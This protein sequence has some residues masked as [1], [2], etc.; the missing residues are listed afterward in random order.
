MEDYKIQIDQLI[1]RQLALFKADQ[2][3]LESYEQ[4]RTFFQHLFGQP[5]F[6]PNPQI[7]WIEFEINQLEK[8]L[9]KQLETNTLNKPAGHE[10]EYPFYSQALRSWSA[11]N[12]S[13]NI[14]KKEIGSAEPRNVVFHNSKALEDS[15]LFRAFMAGH[16]TVVIAFIKG[17]LLIGGYAW[18]VQVNSTNESV[19]LTSLTLNRLVF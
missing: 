1:Q 4:Q 7:K 15:R 17:A 3:R 6:V 11:N 18:F 10:R 2:K 19:S 16:H 14:L 9:L 12:Q 13:S 8:S 5:P